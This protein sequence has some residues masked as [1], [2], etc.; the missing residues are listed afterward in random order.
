MG[1]IIVGTSLVGIFVASTVAILAATD[2]SRPEMSRLVF[3]A[4]LPVLGTWVGTVLAF[5]FARDNMEAASRVQQA[6]TDASIQLNRQIIGQETPVREVMIKRADMKVASYA[7]GSGPESVKLEDLIGIMVNTG[8]LRV[9]VLDTNGAVVS[10]VHE[11]TLTKFAA[12]QG[13]TLA[14]LTQTL[15]DLLAADEYKALITAIGFVTPTDRVAVARTKM[16][17]TAGC[18]DIFVTATG[19]ASEAVEGWLTNTDLATIK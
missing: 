8:Y 16:S 2:L 17:A 7:A 18:N 12:G 11:S 3:T 1:L 4:T 15:N 10:V 5:Y 13:K 6:A 19:A 14:Q 9:P